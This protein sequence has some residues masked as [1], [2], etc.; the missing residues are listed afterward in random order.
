MWPFSQILLLLHGCHW[1]QPVQLLW[2]LLLSCDALLS[3]APPD[4]ASI[5]CQC[6]VTKQWV[7]PVEGE[8]H[9]KNKLVVLTTEWLPWLQSSCGYES[10]T[11][12][13]G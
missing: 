11:L 5:F 9:C 7:R 13:T 12:V 3:V 2:Q 1:Q 6:L 4:E 8:E 10:F